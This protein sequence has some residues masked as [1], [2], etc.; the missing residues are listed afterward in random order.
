M[1]EQKSPSPTNTSPS[2]HSLSTQSGTHN[3]DRSICDFESFEYHPGENTFRADYDHEDAPPSTAIVSAVAV[4]SDTD[5]LDIEPL[6]SLIDPDALDSLVTSQTTTEGDFRMTFEYHDHEVTASS[7]G[8]L[9]I[10]PPQ[11]TPSA[12]ATDD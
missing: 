1:S 3:L 10:R 9:Q 5:P 8:T 4:A 11:S 12:S 7:Y 2:E 6:Q